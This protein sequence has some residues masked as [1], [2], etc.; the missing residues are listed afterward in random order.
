MK[1]QT[2]EIAI[3]YFPK[4]RG[5]GCHTSIQLQST[6]YHLRLSLSLAIANYFMCCRLVSHHIPFVDR[7]SLYMIAWIF[8]PIPHSFPN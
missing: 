1:A 8:D 4:R 2:Y 7:N 5:T 3:L 6:R